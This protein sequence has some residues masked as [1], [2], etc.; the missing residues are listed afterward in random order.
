MRNKISY[1]IENTNGVAE[2]ISKDDFDFA[3]M[4]NFSYEI[5]TVKGYNYIDT[6]I[7]EVEYIEKFC[8]FI[9]VE[10]NIKFFLKLIQRIHTLILSLSFAQ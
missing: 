6:V 9:I 10:F 2:T 5:E 7:K 4:N 8:G 1:L 3:T